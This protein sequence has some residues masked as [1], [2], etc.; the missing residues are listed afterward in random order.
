MA[1]LAVEPARRVQST[2]TL[3]AGLCGQTLPDGAS[4]IPKAAT[5]TSTQPAVRKR[6]RTAIIIMAVVAMFVI[7]IGA[8]VASDILGDRDNQGVVESSASQDGDSQNQ[9]V[10]GGSPDGM[11]ESATE[12]T[13]TSSIQTDGMLEFGTFEGQA[14]DWR[15]LA[16]E[17]GRA[18]IISEHVLEQRPYNEQNAGVTWET[19]TLRQHL[20][21][22]FLQTSFSAEEQLR[23]ATITNQN[24]DNPEY[25]TPGGNPT[26]D[27]VF[28]LSINEA[29]G[30]FTS[31][32]DRL[33]DDLQG[34]VCRWW[35]RS[36]G[37]NDS[38]A[39]NFYAASVGAGDSG[40]GRVD[41]S[42][43]TPSLAV[44]L[45]ANDYGVRPVLWLN[46]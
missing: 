4:G 34:Y 13:S 26:K 33:A 21:G 19:C 39:D 9:T 17:D 14:I 44:A 2:S 20:N 16:V 15:V 25:G 12:D 43:G 22:E 3:K 10:I 18:L 46:L 24:P 45:V 6:P 41:V 11:T 1:A 32:T 37:R 35:L 40:G 7:G 28:L 23:I 5:P 30:Y 31:N 42:G 38:N 27:Q 29:E 36:P 8:L